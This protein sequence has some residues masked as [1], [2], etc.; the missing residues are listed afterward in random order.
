MFLLNSSIC[1]GIFFFFNIPSKK[2]MYQVHLKTVEHSQLKEKYTL[3]TIIHC[4]KEKNDLIF[5]KG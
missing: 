4:K 3:G 5:R 1:K 2:K